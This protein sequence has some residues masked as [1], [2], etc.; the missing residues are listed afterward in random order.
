MRIIWLLVCILSVSILTAC[1]PKNERQAL[2]IDSPYFLPLDHVLPI[3]GVNVRYRDEGPKDA[4]TIVMV[5]GFT[6][7]LETWDALAGELKSDYRVI[8]LDLAGHGLTG[9]DPQERY[10]ND[11][12]VALFEDFLN[13][14]DIEGSVHI[15]NSLGG[16]IS[17]RLAAQSPELVS[18]L[19][20]ISPGGFSINGVT[21]KPVE[22]PAMV[23]AYL[24]MAPEAGVK[25]ATR[26]LFADPEKLSAERIEEIGYMMRRDGNGDAFIKRAS[27]FTLPDPLQDL[28]KVKAPALIIWGDKDAIVPVTHG[29][30][31][32]DALP[33]A[34]LSIY[35]STGHVPQEERP[36]K[37]SND[38][39]A[40]LAEME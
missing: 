3:D 34:K 36:V 30:K 18:K 24:A 20:L 16:L 7:S 26:A 39:R 14:L 12:T 15:G 31:F 38:I 29:Q 6:S 27:V 35:Q 37:L 1:G 10:T 19:V 23:Q 40:F 9:P 21:D 22:V 2:S 25:Q 28:V 33:N 11:D 5:H 4:E 8:R 32:V 13:E 17:W